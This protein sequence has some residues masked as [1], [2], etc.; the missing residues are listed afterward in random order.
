MLAPITRENASSTLEPV[1][2]I[3]VVHQPV[4]LKT[5]SELDFSQWLEEQLTALETQYA[6]FHTAECYKSA[7]GR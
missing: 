1:S 5:D 3:P 6:A 7:M 4:E 2:T